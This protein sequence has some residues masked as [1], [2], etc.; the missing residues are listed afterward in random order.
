MRAPP[1][2]GP[3]TARRA[4]DPVR[5]ERGEGNTRQ[6]KSHL[7]ALAILWGDEGIGLSL[8][9]DPGTAVDPLDQD[10]PGR[11]VEQ[12]EQPVVADPELALVRSNPREKVASRIVGVRLQFSNDPARDWRVEPA[13][14][15]G[16]GF[17]PAYRPRLQRFSLRLNSSWPTVR[18]A[19]MSSLPLSSPTRNAA[20]YVPSSSPVGTRSS[21]LFRSSS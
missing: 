16:A 2:G 12:G 3:G 17:R 4:A 7:A 10:C 1:A 11:G 8:P 6:F 15:A 9:V 5:S 19:R 21:S 13:E 20:R 18:P 14:V